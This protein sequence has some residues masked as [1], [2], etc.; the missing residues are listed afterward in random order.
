[1]YLKSIK[2]IGFKSFADKTNVEFNKEITAVVGPNGSG[3]SNI[4]DAIR[5]VLGEQSVKQLRGSLVMSDVIFSGSKSRDA[6]KKASVTL[7]FDN[8]DNYL[9]SEFKE[10]EIKREVYKTGENDYYIN[11]VR[12]RLKDIHDLF[13]DTGAGQGA[14]NIISQ[15]NITE[16]VNSKAYDRRI[17]FESAACVLKYKKRKEEALRKLDKTKDNLHMIKLVIDELKVTVLPLKKQSENAAKYLSYKSSLENIEISLIASDIEEYSA[18]LKE[19]ETKIETLNLTL[20]RSKT[21]VD[22]AKIEKLKFEVTKIEDLVAD[23]NLKIIDINEKIA[24]LTSEKTLTL[25]RQKFSGNNVDIDNNLI[26]LKEKSLEYKKNI[27]LLND[28]LS[29]LNVTKKELSNKLDELSNKLLSDKVKRTHLNANIDSQNKTIIYLQNKIEIL[30]NNINND[31]ML[32]KAVRS[33]LNNPKFSKVHN[34]IGNLIKTEESYSV[35]INAALGASSNFLVTEDFDCAKEAIKYLKTNNLGKA[36]FFPLDTIKGRYIPS[37]ITAM[38]KTGSDF[39]GVAADLVKYDKKYNNIIL[40]QLGNV[41]IV[42]NI[43]ALNT[44]GKKLDYKYKLVS[45]DGDILYTGGS[46]YGGKDK[47]S[48]ISNLQLLKNLKTNLVD[49]KN[50]LI[51]L[52]SDYKLI[53]SNYDT[54]EDNTNK[55]SKDL[56]YLKEDISSKLISLNNLN[57]NYERIESELKGVSSLKENSFENDLL[58]ISENLS[59]LEKEKAILL[60]QKETYITKKGDLYL[61]ITETEHDLRKKNSEVYAINTE[62]K[63]CEIAKSKLE[64]KLENLLL[65]L[66]EDYNLTYE[67]ATLQGPLDGDKVE[68]R[69]EVKSLKKEIEKLG[70]VNL[71]AIAEY[72]RLSVRYDFLLTQ[73]KDLEEASSNLTD[74][75]SEMDEIMIAKFK[76]SFNKIAYEFKNV[77][78]EIFG[79]G[80]GEL[81]LSNPDDLLNTGVEIIAEPPGKKINSTIA[82]SGGEK[83]LTAICLLFSIL[84]VRP[85]PFIILDEAEAA[86]DE[87]NVDMFGKYISEKKK[88]SQ[89]I[90]ITHKKRMMEYADTLYGITMQESGVSK[91]VSTKL[92]NK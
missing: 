22:N 39:I 43:D 7:T 31:D 86:L 78:K 71:G 1:M 57:T 36:T 42:K 10:V 70:V 83:S 80:K 61:E 15:G 48:I 58:L 72:E 25:E 11:N 13:L 20:E 23:S 88:E 18:N 91:L 40:N 63:E 44:I 37:D 45:L 75:I 38:L 6:H 76:E 56:I 14:F 41:I 12:V 35:A 73:E 74:I 52:E 68:L 4:V 87:A 2:A 85:V 26:S 65:T 3:K 81:S 19:V 47:N 33:I 9:K 92:E 69:A 60:D 67:A 90:L 51:K 62:L 77:F 50:K 24:K 79:G 53:N 82:L 16:I 28:K 54:L 8:S 34:T 21:D 55:V 89:F 27:D 59:N 84:N 17:I 49:E 66:S 32:P 64:F 30:E 5:W 46:L 29:N